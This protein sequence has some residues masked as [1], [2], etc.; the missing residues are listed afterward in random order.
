MKSHVLNFHKVHKVPATI[1][2][3]LNAI[4]KDGQFKF[5]TQ[6]ENPDSAKVTLTVFTDGEKGKTRAKVF[7][8]AGYEELEQEMNQFLDT[9]VKMKF[10]TQSCVGNTVLAVVFYEDAAPT[11]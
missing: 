8:D 6:V 2:D 5:A 10:H 1:E 7:R 4:L 3:K 9:G 11:A